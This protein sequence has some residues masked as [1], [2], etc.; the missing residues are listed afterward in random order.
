[1]WPLKY[2][3]GLLY[4]VL[5][6]VHCSSPLCLVILFI[7]LAEYQSTNYLCVFCG[8]IIYIYFGNYKMMKCPLH[9]QSIYFECNDRFFLYVV[10]IF[11]YNEW[12]LWNI[13]ICILNFSI[14]VVNIRCH[15]EISES[16][17]F[18]N[19]C[20]LWHCTYLVSKCM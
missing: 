2:W 7:N 20:V 6:A 5:G 16:F 11:F 4:F 15:F 1:M 17:Q 8:A 13:L 14:S 19:I 10:L 18:V 9:T 12:E 3:N